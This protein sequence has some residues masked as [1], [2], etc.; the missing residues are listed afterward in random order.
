MMNGRGQESP[1]TGRVQYR[2]TVRV[3]YRE[4]VR[5]QVSSTTVKHNKA[6][7]AKEM[8]G[9]LERAKKCWKA[10]QSRAAQQR[11]ACKRRKKLSI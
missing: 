11:S 10:K 7:T 1:E 2:E 8:K 3:Q 9:A 4:T 6:Y 5:V